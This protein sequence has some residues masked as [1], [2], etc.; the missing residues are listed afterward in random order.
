MKMSCINESELPNRILNTCLKYACLFVLSLCVYSVN[1]QN[2]SEWN[3]KK[4]AVIL[5]YDDAIDEHLDHVI[6]VLDSLGLRATFY[7]SVNSSGFS[8]RTEEWIQVAKNDHE[9]G[10]HTMYHPCAG[11]LPGRDWV[12]PEYDLAKYSLKRIEQEIL[13]TNFIL[14]EIDGKRERTFAYP[15]GEYKVGDTSY[16]NVVEKNFISARGVVGNL[17]SKN[18]I[19]YFNVDS[20]AVD[21]NSTDDLIDLV[22]DARRSGKMLVFMFHGVG[23]GHPIN[24]DLDVHSELLHYLKNNEKDIWVVSMVEV[25]QYLK[26]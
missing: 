21:G 15:C 12:N 4:C 19:D 14:G 18:D 17:V 8:E 22:E 6:P 2:S 7:L 5:T 9:L 16:T 20:Y 23:G 3:G 13:A 26:K 11:N 24:V 1:A 10:N 25:V